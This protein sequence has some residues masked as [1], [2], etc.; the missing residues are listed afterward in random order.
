VPSRDPTVSRRLLLLGVAGAG[1]A[2]VLARLPGTRPAA[3]RTAVLPAVI[4]RE[5]RAEPVSI[6]GAD[7]PDSGPVHEL[8]IAGGRVMDPETGFDRDAEVAVDGGVITAIESEGLE[9]RN[10]IDAAGLVVAPGFIDLLSYDPNPY[11]V[12]FK[13]ADGVTTTMGMHGLNDEAAPFFERWGNDP[14]PV[15]Y[16]GAFDH[17][18]ARAQLG[19]GVTEAA[20]P[21]QLRELRAQAERG[22]ADG[23]AGIDVEPEY[24]PGATTAELEAMGA[25][26]SAAGVTLYAHG[27]YSD[28]TPPGTNAETLDE[29]L[30]IAR[31]TGTSL[32]VQHI[33]STGG[34]FTMP[35]SLQ[36]LADARDDGMDVTACMYPYDFW[37]TYLG[38]TRFADGWQERF[39]I[40][41]EDLL[42][43]G[44]GE[45]L[46]EAS[47]EREQRRNT[48]VAAMA[49]PEADVVAGLQSSF[50]M[51]GSDAVLEE[52]DNN[53]PRGAGTFCRV[54]GRYVRE[55]RVLSLRDALAKMTVIPAQ[56]LAVGI[57]AFA[58]K[59]RI[60][61]GA[62]ADLTLFD[63][64]EVADRATIAD[65][66]IQS[67]G[68]R[69][70][71]VN[72][73][74]VK[75]PDGLQRDVRPGRPL[76]RGD[77]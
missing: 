60:Q 34:T 14:P 73:Q 12:W 39:H 26:A 13:V 40:S 46:D 5:P 7:P 66:S 23:W 56:R 17:P 38:S 69:W 52:G 42:V 72:G 37:A 8:V 54:L 22:L 10:R 47:F 11:G 16:G 15:N 59:G 67:V 4:E 55:R 18:F 29:L 63:P 61:V 64:D 48:L 62:D 9:G 68:V 33:T 74:A 70:V 57:P 58:R 36:T 2:T 65:P 49:I 45:R 53:H 25:V 6:E 35:A 50:V 43:P 51:I 76:K 32:H 75:T 21:E 19:L 31:A 24:T 77:A 44:T 41:Y 3:A 71:L 28:D 27:R 30:R 1:G 20:S